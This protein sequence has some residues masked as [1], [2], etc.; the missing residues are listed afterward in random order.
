MDGSW[1]AGW[2]SQLGW[3]GFRFLRGVGPPM[4]VIKDVGPRLH[5]ELPPVISPVNH[6]PFLFGAYL[7]SQPYILYLR[8]LKDAR[9]RNCSLVQCGG[10]RLCLLS[11][12]RSL[13]EGSG[14][15]AFPRSTLNIHIRCCSRDLSRH[16][17]LE[18]SLTWI[19]LP[20]VVSPTTNL[21]CY[22]AESDPE[23]DDE[24]P[25]EDPADYPTNKDDDEEEEESSRDIDA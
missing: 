18:K 13:E 20:V 11:S 1:V 19:P 24:D 2:L 12:A 8:T 22:I 21:P 6:A 16:R 4:L 17:I 9:L 14:K 3:G 25:D 10:F 23:E 7:R 5:G 15:S